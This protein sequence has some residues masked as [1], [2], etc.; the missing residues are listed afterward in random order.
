MM[1]RME[2]AHIARQTLAAFRNSW[3]AFL[4]IHVAANACLVLV[5]MPVYTLLSGWLILAS[6]QAALTDEDI[7]LFALTPVGL[8]VTGVLAALSITLLIFEF[9]AL[10]ITAFQESSGRKVGVVRLSR[11]LLERSWPLFLLALRM[12]GRTLAAAAP[13]LAVIAGIFWLFLTEFDINFYLF[14]RPPVFIWSAAAAA[15][16]LLAM[17]WVLLRIFAGWIVALPLVLIERQP[18]G[19]ALLNSRRLA[20][21]IRRLV[22]VILLAWVSIS[23]VLLGVSGLLL[24]GGVTLAQWLAGDSLRT[25]AYLMGGLLLLWS[26]INLVITF[27]SNTILVLLILRL[28]RHLFPESTGVRL[29]SLEPARIARNLKLSGVTLAVLL[30]IM[31]VGAGFMLDHTVDRLNTG[32][33][34]K[35]IA[36][37]GASID[38]PDNTLAAMEEAIRQ[39]ADYVEIDVQET[40]EGEIVVIHDR[41]LM[42]VGGS[43]LRVWDAPLPALQ[44]VDVGSWLDPVFS[45]QRVPTLQELLALCKDRVRVN[46]EL[47]YYG[48]EQRFEELV[49]TIV[50]DMGMADQVV[51]MSLNPVG[52]RKLKS[53][54]PDWRVGLLTSVAIG[55]VTRLEADFFAVNGRFASRRFVR[56]A[57]ARGRQVLVWTINDPVQMAAM[58]GR[59]VDG[60]I[61]DLP[62]LAVEIRGQRADLEP[63]ERLMLQFAGLLGWRLGSEQ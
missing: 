48:R 2:T 57:H 3:K 35:V 8:L 29:S 21:K 54:R 15:L 34:A 32:G 23:T 56:S 52:V 59:E 18:P 62:G 4:F 1:G 9:A 7:L 43:P 42:M 27:F 53:L 13:F 51:A 37:R 11:Y 17:A 40:A 47:K 24:D 6:G 31:V 58:M 60:I 36:H 63:Y 41:D 61:T 16:I 28:Y 46:I 19:E 26:L 55:D 25:M 39:G 50:E 33:D 30:A 10:F 22:A 20:G 12:V 45:D 5:I 38:A 49:V 14:E 44:S